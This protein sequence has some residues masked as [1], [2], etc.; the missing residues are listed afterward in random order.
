MS[1]VEDEIDYA[2]ETFIGRYS[3]M[4]DD[5]AA[6]VPTKYEQLQP[7]RS[8]SFLRPSIT[9]DERMVERHSSILSVTEYLG[10][11]SNLYFT[12]R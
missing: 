10:K 9:E 4:Y 12:Q 5:I 6:D 11:K 2:S 8:S 1:T 3:C 7:K